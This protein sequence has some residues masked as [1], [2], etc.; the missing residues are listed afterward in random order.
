MLMGPPDSQDILPNL[1]NR[2]LRP[3]LSGRSHRHAA[4]MTPY[5]RVEASFWTTPNRSYPRISDEDTIEPT[6]EAFAT[7]LAIIPGR[8]LNRA[9]S[10]RMVFDFTLHLNP[11]ATITYQAMI[12]NNSEVFQIAQYGQVQELI[13]ALAQGT[14]RLTDRDEEGRSLLNV[15]CN[16]LFFERI[17]E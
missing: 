4:W 5:G 10:F 14:A 6:D 9:S 3:F 11:S 12:P 8:N 7:R 16:K 1:S 15:S 2:S 17:I 13:S